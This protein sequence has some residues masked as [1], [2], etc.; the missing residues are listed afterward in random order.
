MFRKIVVGTD[1][2]DTASV[3]VGHAAA[4]AEKT[5]A[6]LLVVHSYTAERRSGESPFVRDE[7]VPPA[8]AGR[9]VLAHEQ[10]RLGERASVRTFLEEGNPADVILDVAEAEDADL[11]VVGNVGMS[12]ARRFM[13]SVP[14]NV[15]HHSPTNVLVV[16]TRWAAD[17][18][19]DDIEATPRYGTVL[20]GTDGSGTASQAMEVGAGL[21]RALGASVVLVH[22]GDEE[23]GR[24]VLDRTAASIGDGLEVRTV[25]QKGQPAEAIVAVAER[26]GADLIVVGNKGMTG[27]KRFLLGSVPNAIAHHASTDVLVAKTT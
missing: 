14:N 7:G 6:E 19:A 13:G 2:S 22:V 21:A 24:A 20:M 23:T 27:A 8:E 9:S 17:A 3:A 10:K 4:L 12:G 26:E 11:I 25:M 18:A 15:A 5:G 16:N 1:G